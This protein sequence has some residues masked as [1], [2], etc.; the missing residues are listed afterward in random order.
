[1]IAIYARQS[2]DKK[3]SVS[4]ETQIEFCK[5]EINN[6]EPYKIYEDKGFSGK[7]IERPAF[8]E[9]SSAVENNQVS[10]VI[11]YRLDRISRSITDFAN[12][13]KM[14]EDNNVS[15]VSST[16]KFDTGA[17]MGRAM[18]Y[19]IMVF[20]QLERETLAERI[21]DNY[22]SRGKNGVFLGGP[23]PLGFVNTTAILDGK[24]IKVL[25]QTE[26]IEIVKDIFDEYANTN[27]S[28]GVIARK[29]KNI[30]GDKYGVWNNIKLSRILHNPVYVKANADIY[31]HYSQKNCIMVNSIDEYT[32][33]KA[34]YV[35]G[36]RDRSKSK[37]RNLSEHVVVLAQ[38]DGIIE[39]EIFLRCHYKLDQNQQIKNTG[40]GKYTWLTGLIKCGYCGSSLVVKNYEGRNK[41]LYCSGKQ[42]NLCDLKRKTHYLLTV[43]DYV[44]NEI[45]DLLKNGGKKKLEI[46]QQEG[47]EKNMLKIELYKIEEQIKKLIDSLVISNEVTVDYLNK[48]IVELDMQKK[49]IQNKLGKFVYKE[50]FVSL[51]SLDDWNIAD[52]EDKRNIAVTLIAKILV[53]DSKIAVEWK[54]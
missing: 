3:D 7:N 14:F 53:Y 12:I 49:E 51:P 25:K 46:E 16:E 30:Y 27:K 29:F 35:Y 23:P 20:A 15:F 44:N 18:L 22:Y 47:N 43:E 31:N 40:K 9:L 26:D 52:M 10:K 48:R 28:L 38:H 45:I 4:I 5:K 6:D 24:N 34:C 39:P 32:G 1:M 41:Y 37:Y 21:K 11:V 13:L 50:N 8:A 54:H 2:M 42:N 36:K 17:P 19:I 33:D